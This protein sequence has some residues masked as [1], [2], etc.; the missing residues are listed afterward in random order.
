MEISILRIKQHFSLISPFIYLFT[1]I[2]SVPSYSYVETIPEASTPSTISSSAIS[3]RN[4]VNSGSIENSANITEVLIALLAIVFFIFLI[5][6]IMK[7]VGYT[8][9]PKNN[10]MK[11]KACLPLSSKERLLLVEI[12]N[13]QVVIG[14]VPGS[15]SLI[16]S[17]DKPLLVSKPS[18][19][20]K[21]VSADSF[22]LF[23]ETL[24]KIISRN[25][26]NNKKENENVIDE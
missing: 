5:A 25:K 16:K 19:D 10:F 3:S 12:G 24:S 14:V 4:V 20:A 23:S 6:W 26:V 17:L 13:E 15:I 2:F 22:P 18:L 7:R 9:M 21:V 11:I 8:G 1:F